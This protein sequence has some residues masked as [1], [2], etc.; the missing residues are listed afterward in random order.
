[1]EKLSQRAGFEKSEAVTFH[2]DFLE[3]A[4]VINKLSRLVFLM[5]NLFQDYVKIDG[6][7]YGVLMQFLGHGD[8]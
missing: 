3:I 5:F 7:F 8:C 1:M 6:T 4:L 2:C